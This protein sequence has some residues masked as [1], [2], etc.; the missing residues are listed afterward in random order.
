[1]LVLSRKKN[2]KIVIDGNTVI[3][4]LDVRGDTVRIGIQAPAE[5]RVLR[6][7]LVDSVVPVVVDDPKPFRATA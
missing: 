3:T 1:M 7:E 5:I 4:V 2:E 6:G